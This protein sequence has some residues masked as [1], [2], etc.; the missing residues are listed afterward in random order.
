MSGLAVVKLQV[1]EEDL[2]WVLV[3]WRFL[4]NVGTEDCRVFA[5]RFLRR[6]FLGSEVVL[7]VLLRRLLREV[8]FELILFDCDCSYWTGRDKNVF[9][10][11]RLLKIEIPTFGSLPPLAPRLKNFY[12]DNALLPPANNLTQ[13]DDRI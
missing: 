2:L 7:A 5:L 13:Y 11:T 8:R 3:L 10:T 12:A 6:C 1:V 9:F 4:A